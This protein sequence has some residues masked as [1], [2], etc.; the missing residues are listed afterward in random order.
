MAITA[1]A[2]NGFL[3]KNISQVCGN[4][5][6]NP[7]DNHCAHFVSHA[8]NYQFG[9]NC[10]IAGSGK[11]PGANLRVQEL[12][13][14]CPVVGKW[15]VR[16]ASLTT[17]LVFVTAASNV[18]LDARTMDNVPQKHIGIFLNGPIW[19][20]SNAQHQV[21]TQLP[22]LFVHHYHGP[23]IELFYGQFPI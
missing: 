10:L 21:V 23:D 3:G 9:Y 12:F 4:G 19:H 1:A 11:T 18:H 16:P 7:S 14:R 2:L 22:E 17:C 15:A 8:L 13:S 6:A 20:Y 5:Y